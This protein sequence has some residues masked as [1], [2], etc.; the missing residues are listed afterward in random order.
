MRLSLPALALVRLQQKLEHSPSATKLH[1]HSKLYKVFTWGRL[2]FEAFIVEH[3]LDQGLVRGTHLT[4]YYDRLIMHMYIYVLVITWPA[5]S[6]FPCVGKVSAFIIY[7]SQKL[8]AGVCVIHE[9]S[10]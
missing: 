6:I 2:C 1:G 3:K 7:L 4:L 5:R 9:I 8:K 10:F